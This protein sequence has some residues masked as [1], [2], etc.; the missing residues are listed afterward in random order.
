MQNAQVGPVVV[1]QRRRDMER[2][3]RVFG[4]I[5]WKKYGADV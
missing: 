1:S 4:E 5:S 3:Q 2:W